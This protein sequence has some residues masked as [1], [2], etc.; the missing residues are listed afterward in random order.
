MGCAAPAGCCGRGWPCRSVVGRV[1]CAGMPAGR[2]VSISRAAFSTL[3]RGSQG[4][5][6]GCCR[7]E[8]RCAV[9]AV[10]SPSSAT[11]LAEA[12]CRSRPSSGGTAGRPPAYSSPPMARPASAGGTRPLGCTRMRA[13]W[14][15]GCPRRWPICPTPAAEHRPTGWR[16]RSSSAI[17][18]RSGRR[19]PHRARS[20]TP[21]GWMRPEAAGTWTHRG[22]CRPARCHPWTSCANIPPWPSTSMLITCPPGSL[23]PP[24][25]LSEHPA[26]S[27]F[28]WMGCLPVPATATS[29]M[30]SHRC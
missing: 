27:L 9:E 19:R 11:P 25:T 23:T 17:G 20:P 28:S 26:P 12:R 18:A 21:S 1:G 15:C 2:S 22:G 6:R 14:N 16:A 5:R 24:A 30:Q 29:G 3:R 4:L 13:G 8:C 7:G 10:T